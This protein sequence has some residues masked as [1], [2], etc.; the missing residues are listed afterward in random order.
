[1]SRRIKRRAESGMPQMIEP[2]SDMLAI[3]RLY[4]EK[5]EVLDQSEREIYLEIIASFIPPRLMIA[6]PDFKIDI[7]KAIPRA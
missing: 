7:E 4:L 1:M 6:Q 5:R 3:T 2:N